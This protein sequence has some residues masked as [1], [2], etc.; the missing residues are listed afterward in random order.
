MWGHPLNCK[1]SSEAEDK[2]FSK[3]RFVL[4]AMNYVSL[5]CMERADVFLLATDGHSL[6]YELHPLSYIQMSPSKS[7][8]SS[9]LLVTNAT[10]RAM[11]YKRHLV[12]AGY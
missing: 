12:T 1:S 9:T 11:E 2:S 5:W 4:L 6:S 7:R 8:T 3:P 10:P